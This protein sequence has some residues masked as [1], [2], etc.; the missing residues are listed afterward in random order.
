MDGGWS[1]S[2]LCETCL[3]SRSTPLY[4]GRMPDVTFDVNVIWANLIPVAFGECCCE[5]LVLFWLWAGWAGRALEWGAAAVLN[6]LSRAVKFV[7][8][9]VLR[10][11][12]CIC[13]L[14]F[15]VLLFKNSTEAL[16]STF[17]RI[18]RLPRAEADSGSPV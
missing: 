7:A 9:F 11:F 10:L 13:P 18:M 15:L 3:G 8:P 6:G 17:S 5:V 16:F 1:F 4:N 14:C 12:G 2:S